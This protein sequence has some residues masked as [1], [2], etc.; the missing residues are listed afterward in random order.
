LNEIEIE[1]SE[2]NPQD[3]FGEQNKTIAHLRTY[4][5]KLKI[6]ARGNKIKARQYKMPLWDLSFR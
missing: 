3:F 4:F 1:L 6:I 2:V 5:P